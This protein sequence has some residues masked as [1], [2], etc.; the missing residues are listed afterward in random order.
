M[1]EA[2]WLA[3]EDP[4]KVLAFIHGHTSDRKYRLFA[5]A[6]CRAIWASLA[7]KR[8]QAAVATGERFA[9]GRA[10]TG[11][12]LA[13]FGEAADASAAA[14][15][16]SER[17]YFNALTAEE[18][19]EDETCGLYCG[20]YGAAQSDGLPGEYLRTLIRCVFGN[21]FRPFSINQSWLA[22]NDRCV[23]RLAQAAYEERDLPSGRMD[24][25]RLNILADALEEGGCSDAEVLTH[26][27]GPGPHVR[28]CWVVDLLLE[29]E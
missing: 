14:R 29:K 4:Q 23:V 12:R 17:A 19:V 22:W 15:R 10:S 5:C 7:D 21:H 9:D 18:V 6:C 27:R 28:G 1:T 26:L 8:S 2:E 16:V 25:S 24:T 13:A 11:E 3:C 20:W